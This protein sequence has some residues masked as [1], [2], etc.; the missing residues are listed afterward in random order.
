MK[1]KQ[2]IEEK[3]QEGFFRIHIHHGSDKLRTTKEVSEFDV[4]A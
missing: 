3:T 1:W 2:E 4:G